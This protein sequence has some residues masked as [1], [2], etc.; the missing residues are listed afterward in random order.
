MGSL[1]VFVTEVYRILVHVSYQRGCS[2]TYR[3]TAAVGNDSGS[4]VKS[5]ARS[6]R[7]TLLSLIAII[8]DLLLGEN[9]LINSVCH[10]GLQNVSSYLIPA[11]LQQYIPSDRYHW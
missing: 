2:N 1:I 6:V 8:E 11:W 4:S 10:R 5:P 9:G 7:V 3:L